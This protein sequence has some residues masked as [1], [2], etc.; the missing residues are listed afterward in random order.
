MLFVSCM[1]FSANL[2]LVAMLCS[3]F[4]V[5]HVYVCVEKNSRYYS[6]SLLSEC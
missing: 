5:S 1:V 3:G 2:K 4:I 6:H